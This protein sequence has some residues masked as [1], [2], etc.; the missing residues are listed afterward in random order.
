MDF[1]T[2]RDFSKLSVKIR[3]GR[4]QYNAIFIEKNNYLMLEVNVINDIEFFEKAKDFYKIVNGQIL[5][6][7]IDV[8]LLDCQL[9]NKAV[10]QGGKNLNDI[11]Y[12][13]LCVHTLII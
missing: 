5:F 3:L 7:N 1:N 9:Y 12:T 10:T 8:S 2:F 11:N 13:K 6:N 4:K